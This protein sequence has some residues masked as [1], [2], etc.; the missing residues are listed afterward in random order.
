MKAEE[1]ADGPR[2]EIRT[3][4]DRSDHVQLFILKYGIRNHDEPGR[5]P[6]LLGL[7]GQSHGLYRC[8]SGEKIMYG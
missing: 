7:S 2:I 6:I 8:V 4:K 3:G 5:I 1:P